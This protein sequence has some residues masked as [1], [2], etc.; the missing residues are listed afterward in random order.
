MRRIRPIA[1]APTARRVYGRPGIV[2]LMMLCLTWAAMPTSA[3]ASDTPS[4]RFLS[5]VEKLAALGD[6]STGTPGNKTA[7][8]FIYKELTAI[9]SGEVGRHHFS[10]PVLHHR[11]STMKIPDRGLSL[12]IHPIQGNAISPGT[13]VENGLAGPLYYVGSG[14]LDELNGKQIMGAVVLM[15]MDS[16]RNWL[17]AASLGAKALIYVDKGPTPKA[18]FHDKHELTPIRFPRFW[19]PE[20]RIREVFNDYDTKPGGRL[21]P[22]VQLTSSVNWKA[23]VSENLYLMVPGTDKKLAEELIMVDAFYDS[24]AMVFGKSPGADEACG[25]ATLLEMARHLKE[26][27]PARSVLLIATSGHA[28]TLAGIR[29]LI[30]SVKTRSKE[31]RKL[32]NTLKKAI[33]KNRKIIEALDKLDFDAQ[34]NLG[35]EQGE[36][37]DLVFQALNDQ[38]K[39]E[40]DTIS[41]RLMRLRLKNERSEE[42]T[43]LIQQLA[44]ERLLLRQLGWRTEYQGM[45]PQER[46]KIKALIPLALNRHKTILTDAKAQE[47]RLKESS[48]FRSM[49][50]TMDIAAAISLHLSS[51][52]DGFGPFNQ[53]WLHPLKSII[54]RVAPYG[55]LDDVLRNGAAAVEKSTGLLNVYKDTLRPSR[56]RSWQSYFI[57]KPPLG[58]EITAIAGIHG[59]SFVTTNDAR[60]YWGTPYDLPHT[61]NLKQ[62]LDQSEVIRGLIDHLA[63]APRTHDDI[64]PRDGFAMVSGRVKF[65]RHGELFADQPAPGSMILAYQGPGRYHLM[66]DSMGRFQI[67]GVADKKHV[68]HKVIFEGYKFNPETGETIWAI[69]KKQTGKAAYRVKMQRRTMETDLIMFAAKYTTLFNLLEPRTFRYMTKINILDGRREAQ[70]LRYWWS[71]IDT[72]SSIIAS[73]FLEPGTRLKMTLSDSVLRNKLIL[74]NGTEDNTIGTGYRVDDWPMLYHTDYR[75]A[76]DMW[77][78]LSP[79]IANLEKHGVFS[80]RIRDLQQEGTAALARAEKALSGKKYDVFAE[81]AKA[82]WALAIR[83]YDHVEKT[84]KDVLFGVLFYIA[85]FVPFAFCMER[86]LFSYADI[87]KRIIAFIVILFLVIAVIYKVHP[88]FQLA[89]SPMVVI[90]AFF[91]MGL[92]LIV[93]LIIFFRFE[94][95]M[96]LLQSHAKH[97]QTGE[98]SRW[99]AFT[100]AFFLGVSN[101]RRRRLRTVLT[102]STLIILTFT[103]MSFT[104]VK[105]MRQHT[106]LLLDKQPTHQGFLLKNVNWDNLPPEASDTISNAFEEKAIVA[107]RAWLEEEDRTRATVIPLRRGSHTFQARGLVGLSAQEPAVTGIDKT[108]VGGRWFEQKEKNAVLLPERM[109]V[110]LGIDP[111]NPRD[112]EVLL[113]GVPYRVVGVF[114]GVKFMNHTDLDG[115]P[116]TPVTFP[117]ETT[118]AMTEVEM[119]ALESGDDVRSFQS[120]YKHIAGDL[121]VIVPFHM[122]LALAGGH[123]KSAAVVP[124]SG[125][126]SKAAA[127]KLVDRF[128]LTVFSGEPEGTFLNNA[129]DTMSYSGVPNILIPMVISVFIVLNTMI[130]SVYERK[131]EI[132]IYTSVGLAPSH[133]SFLFIAEALAFAVLSVV[134]GYLL[135]QTSASLFAGTS[136]W[137]GI[138]VNY[139]SMSGVA[140]MVLVILVVLVSVIYPSRVAAQIAIPDVNRSW[141]MPDPKQNVIEVSLPFLVKHSEQ[142]SCSGYLLYHFRGHQDISHGLFSTGDIDVFTDRPAAALVSESSPET[143]SLDKMEEGCTH[144]NARVWLAPFDFGIMQQVEI[145]FMPAKEETGFL[146]IGMKLVRQSGEANAWG[147]INKAFVNELRKQLLVWRSM[148]E[149][150]RR[151]FE[152]AYDA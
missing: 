134:M 7:A 69:D 64:F 14:R 45:S 98:I 11:E 15:D 12:S 99:K 6:R 86:L 123:L 115:E 38:L 145:Y 148:D 139:S 130:G 97:M 21:T 20:A 48:K 57:D 42:D 3:L 10:L 47:K 111:K 101:L 140:A 103:I 113:W 16:G 78:L 118:M 109:A 67:R 124:V 133:V 23:V 84:Q 147:R 77:Q 108:L 90:L 114:S 4:D 129:G 81:A 82:S 105:S 68:L 102:C 27:P 49:V 55:A 32:K 107:P 112:K 94:D 110:N 119:D 100:A 71:R 58:G 125:S 106:R 9:G 5:V 54:N 44:V 87:Y 31:L 122:V 95:E 132:A 25:I 91:I 126:V 13:I 59:L 43:V 136:L 36:E 131:K 1:T 92:S 135:A 29:E 8:D 24:T 80:E 85:L 141:T 96:V 75:V 88:A 142:K 152:A 149:T 65:L 144:I 79:R 53:G 128:G 70:P 46:L 28:Q 22:A 39:T 2:V 61:V 30:W 33:K 74:T 73:I 60:V 51:H 63:I 72:R 137:A 52:G 89:Y 146:T 41:R 62:A 18:F 127:M 104:S 26:N 120:R 117:S 138:T 143:A 151:G 17:H 150:A 56:L 83:V 66:V 40:A 19:I 35:L 34:T 121:T 37:T 76:R 116:L 50:K 93:T